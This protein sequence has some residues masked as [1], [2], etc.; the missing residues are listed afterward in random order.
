MI[1]SIIN[2]RLIQPRPAPDDDTYTIVSQCL[3]TLLQKTRA[4]HQWLVDN[5]FEPDSPKWFNLS[6][7][8]ISPD[9]LNHI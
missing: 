8:N 6:K 7:V 4:E 5:G 1:Q 2:N 9:V 3:I